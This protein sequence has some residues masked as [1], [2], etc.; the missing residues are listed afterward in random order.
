MKSTL[1]KNLLGSSLLFTLFIVACKKDNP[2]VNEPVDENNSKQTPTT[3]RVELTNDSIFLYAKE[4]Y[5]WNDKLPSYDVFEPR[6]YTTGG[7]DLAKYET[8]LFELVKYSG[9]E[10]VEGI[11]GPKFSY[12]ED[13][14]DNN[15]AS[16]GIR[17]LTN[18]VNLQGEGNDVG[19][20]HIG[21]YGPS[22]N[23][24]RVFIKAVFPGSPAAKVGLTRGATITKIGT[25]EIGDNWEEDGPF[26]NQLLGDPSSIHLEGEKADGSSYVAD[27]VKETYDS[28]PIYKDTVLNV[29]GKNIGYLAYARFSDTDNSVEALNVAFQ[30]FAAVQD[31]VIDL[32][33]NGGG[34]VS[35][36]QYLA[37]LVAPTG[38]TGTMFVEYYNALMQDGKASILQN[39]PVRNGNGDIVGTGTY[40]DY[41]YD[42]TTNTRRFEKK[43]PLGGVK[44]VIFLV[45]GNTASS[46]ELLINSLRAVPA[47]TVKIVGTTT[48]GKPV[49]FFPV[50]LEGKYDLY[51]SSFS[52]KNANGDGDYYDGFTPGIDIDGTRMVDGLGQDRDNFSDYD[53]G[54]TRE[55]YLAE[56]LRL[57]GVGLASTSNTLMSTRDRQSSSS[58]N[59]SLNLMKGIQPKKEFRGMIE[60]RARNN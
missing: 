55:L 44:N 18:G 52:T 32:R 59:T 25:Q 51:L 39:Q 50:R 38:T 1:F 60:T 30:K 26:I 37:D 11:D 14:S 16:A 54:D 15:G 35:T 47:L 33:Y 41:G 12:I 34:Y 53:F 48:Y 57:L 31:L 22:D 4:I 21:A 46:S 17:N 8:N 40:A 3:N 43:G 5:Y 24:Y 29:G 23:D 20:Y 42:V 19:I 13:V 45:T 2:I 27:L 7:P 36:A 10:H 49:G 9:Y 6:Q 28:S 58:S 56:A